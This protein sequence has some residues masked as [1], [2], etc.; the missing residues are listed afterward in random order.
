MRKLA[1]CA[2]A[3]MLAHV[4]LGRFLVGRD[5]VGTILSGG[6]AHPGLIATALAFVLLRLF[7]VVV[8]PAC[9]LGCAGL[10]VYDRLR[11]PKTPPARR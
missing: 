9:A 7:V 10:V 3:L 4:L 11:R 1:A 6:R 5:V 2:L 8:L